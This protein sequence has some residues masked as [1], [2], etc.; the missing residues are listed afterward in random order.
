VIIIIIII[1]TRSFTDMI[2]ISFVHFWQL[3]H[4]CDT[5]LQ[6]NDLAVMLQA[7]FG[8]ERMCSH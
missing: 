2:L 6:Q 3:G 4:I 1:I 5:I 8:D 7:A